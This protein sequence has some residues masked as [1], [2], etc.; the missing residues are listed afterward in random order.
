MPELTVTAS[1]PAPAAPSTPASAAATDPAATAPEVSLSAQ[2]FATILQHQLSGTNGQLLIG[3]LPVPAADTAETEVPSA[4]DSPLVLQ[5][6]DRLLA[7]L[8]PVQPSKAAKPDLDAE[9]GGT[10]GLQAAMPI[11]IAAPL[12]APPMPQQA[13]LDASDSDKPATAGFSAT[14]PAASLAAIVAERTATMAGQQESPPEAV[15]AEELRAQPTLPGTSPLAGT[16]QTHTPASENATALRIDAPLGSRTW[17]TELGERLTWMVGRQEQRAD[18][19]LN[20]PQLGRIEI[21]LSLSGNDATAVFTSGNSAVREAIEN[22]LPKLREAFLDAGVNLG[23]TQ[24]G[25]QSQGQWAEAEKNR[26]NPAQ[27][28][29][30][31]T[32][33]GPTSAGPAVAATSGWLRGGRGLVDTFA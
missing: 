5:F 30:A 8:S 24:I 18:L 6:A 10:D 9:G 3:G 33:S 1:T 29:V 22:A 19:V 13:L 16:S 28:E 4:Q 27:E 15:T 26:D 17:A 31:A 14:T 25:A 20:P 7:A 11:P 32:I 12:V 21:S 2:T 23:Q